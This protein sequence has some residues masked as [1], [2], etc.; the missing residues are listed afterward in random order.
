MLLVAGPH[1]A[2]H[3]LQHNY[4]IDAG[5]AR[6]AVVF[7]PD[8]K[9]V[10]H[11]LFLSWLE[12]AA[13]AVSAYY[14]KFPARRLLVKIKIEPGSKMRFSTTAFEGGRP[15]IEIP[16]G[17]DIAADELKS[18]WVA[19]HE[20][21]HLAFPMV[22]YPSRWVAEGQATYIEPLARLQIG[23]RTP[24]QVWGDLAAHLPSG[25]PKEGDGGLN[26]SRGI[27]RVYWGGALFCLLGDIQIRQQTHNEKGFQD[28]AAAILSAGGDIGSDWS[29]S[30]A[31]EEGD[32]AVGGHVLGD[33]YARM[34]D[35]PVNTDLADL[36]KQLGVQAKKEQIT[37]DNSA[38]LAAVRRAIELGHH[39]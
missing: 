35:T 7:D 34:G 28:A 20:M 25:L 1:A 27:G 36:W 14:G 21:T 30:R 23:D 4:Y 15:V 3:G 32:K 24:E 5:G 12:T 37:F 6:I 18:N 29:A 33:L 2:A 16:V 26:G 19:T 13:K 10:R 39:P 8:S 22:D 11:E 31:L 38:P 17:V 9:Q